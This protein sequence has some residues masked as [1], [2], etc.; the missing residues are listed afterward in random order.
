M[1][2]VME[3]APVVGQPPRTAEAIAAD[4]TVIELS[5]QADFEVAYVDAMEFPDDDE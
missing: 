2:S 5:G 3:T 1:S 4:C